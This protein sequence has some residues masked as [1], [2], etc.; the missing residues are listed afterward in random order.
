M[1]I[2]MKKIIQPKHTLIEK[3]AGELAAV[4]YETGRS[5]GLTSKHKNARAYAKANLEKFIPKAVECCLKMLEPDSNATEDMKREIYEALME[6][7]NDEELNQYLPNID[8][9][10]AIELSDQ[11]EKKKVINIKGLN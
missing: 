11:M 4:W 8:V 9:K 3:I 7:H 1:L 6:R 5:Q 10:K 2:K